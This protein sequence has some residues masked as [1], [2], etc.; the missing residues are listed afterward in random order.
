VWGAQSATVKA[1]RIL[2]WLSVALF[3]VVCA[4]PFR[5]RPYDGDVNRYYGNASQGCPPALV[6]S[7][8][9]P[10]GQVGNDTSPDF[11]RGCQRTGAD[12]VKVAAAYL[13]PIWLV[14]LIWLKFSY[15]RLER[16]APEAQLRTH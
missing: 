6:A 9:S 14:T 4:L 3:T 15:R 1:A 5:S 2:F 16:A 7:L 11:A 12:R 10:P 13:G 8:R